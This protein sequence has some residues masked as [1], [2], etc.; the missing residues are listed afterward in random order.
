MGL[1]WGLFWLRRLWGWCGASGRAL[2]G[3][4]DQRT[5]CGQQE[6]IG[7]GALLGE[8]VDWQAHQRAVLAG[9]TGIWFGV[10]GVVAVG[11][12]LAGQVAPTVIELNEGVDLGLGVE[13]LRDV[14]H[15]PDGYPPVQ[16]GLLE[17]CVTRTRLLRGGLY[18]WRLRERVGVPR[19]LCGF[20]YF[21][22]KG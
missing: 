11:E 13:V 5:G 18:H 1:R 14:A 2:C 17:G 22:H 4:V 10:L 21:L 15:H 12:G 19:A 8:Q 9:H 20:R 7:D 3:V 6:G 16:Q